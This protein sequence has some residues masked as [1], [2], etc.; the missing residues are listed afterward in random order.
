MINQ[1]DTGVTTAILCET[2]FR[3][4]KTLFYIALFFTLGGR[5]HFSGLC[6]PRKISITLNA[7]F[8][9]STNFSTSYLGQF[10]YTL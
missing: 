9:Q 8:I 5:Q 2:P 4:R 10:K 6:T 7:T 3:V 1:K